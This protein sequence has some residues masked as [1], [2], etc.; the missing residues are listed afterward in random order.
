MNV[1]ARPVILILALSVPVAAFLYY[2]GPIALSELRHAT[3]REPVLEVPPRAKLLDG[4]SRK[5]NW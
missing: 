2:F 5:S 3:S 1:K 4:E